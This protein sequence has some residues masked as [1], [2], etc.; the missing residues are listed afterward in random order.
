V[1]AGVGSW[2]V[3]APFP[4]VIGV[5]S[6]MLEL[7]PMLGPILATGAAVAITVPQGFP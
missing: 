2:L 7:V 3:G 4:V 5:L 6:G 1:S